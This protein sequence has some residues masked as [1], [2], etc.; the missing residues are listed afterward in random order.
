MKNTFKDKVI[1]IKQC[2]N[3]D[4]QVERI[5]DDSTQIQLN[6]LF[7]LQTLRIFSVFCKHIL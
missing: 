1:S 2:E 7:S 5:I 6:L 4:L 3:N